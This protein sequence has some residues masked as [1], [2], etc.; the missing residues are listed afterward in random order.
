MSE[1]S[2]VMGFLSDGFPSYKDRW[3][4]YFKYNYE[5]GQEQCEVRTWR[6]IY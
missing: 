4:V 5:E 2:D 1:K 6:N 3:K